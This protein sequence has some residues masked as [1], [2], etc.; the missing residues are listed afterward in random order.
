VTTHLTHARILHR[1][2]RRVRCS[3]C[4]LQ[5]SSKRMETIDGRKLCWPSCNRNAENAR[6]EAAMRPWPGCDWLN[7]PDV[8]PLEE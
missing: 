5:Y 4:G 6:L 7:P 2:N 3:D 1:A 8:G